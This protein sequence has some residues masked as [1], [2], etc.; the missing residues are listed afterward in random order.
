M[1]MVSQWSEI[2]L[3]MFY[4]IFDFYKDH[5]G[6]SKDKVI[7][8]QNLSGKYYEEVPYTRIF[9]GSKINPLDYREWNGGICSVF[10]TFKETLGVEEIEN[11]FSI[12]NLCYV[13]DGMGPLITPFG[14]AKKN[15]E[16]FFATSFGDMNDV[17]NTSITKKDGMHARLILWFT[18][19]KSG[20]IVYD[21]SRKKTTLPNTKRFVRIRTMDFSD[22]KQIVEFSIAHAKMPDEFVKDDIKKE[23]FGK[24]IELGDD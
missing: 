16:T 18:K 2:D 22:W 15:I 17:N 10:D 13:A 23:D 9:L 8:I 11:E 3:E 1:D 19:D 24:V 14:P 20:K 6:H 5:K 4:E 12:L 21:M 7:E